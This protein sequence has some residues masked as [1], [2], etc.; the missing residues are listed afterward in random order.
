MK[1]LNYWTLRRISIIWL[2]GAL[3]LAL[4]L[5]QPINLG[6]F[7]LYIAAAIP[8]LWLGAG[9]LM[10]RI[11]WLAYTT[12]ATAL[13]AGIILLLP[14]EAPNPAQL[15]AEYI[16]QLR[17]YEGTQYVWGGENRRGIDCSGLVR[18]ALIDS[19]FHLGITQAN[20]RA[21]RSAIDLWW[22][23]ASAQAL[24]N[25]YL[26]L[27]APLADATSIN[28]IEA[29]LQ[30]G[31]LAV[32]TDCVHVLAYLGDQ[33]WIEADPSD[34]QALIVHTPSDNIWFNKPVT[35]VRWNAMKASE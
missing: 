33:Q 17:D 26:D 15:R 9:V 24:L 21:L 16:K 32:T 19:Y 34:K 10:W 25:G 11:R 23:D 3:V 35:L 29:P 30:R 4:V 2:V 20:P 14:G 18:R 12:W 22:N 28:E 31:D 27:T 5:Y 8:A 6:I 1:P 7:R 13:L